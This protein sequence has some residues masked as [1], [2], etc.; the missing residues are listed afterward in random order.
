VDRV[1][2]VGN[3]AGLGAQD[4]LKNAGLRTLANQLAF[5]VSYHEISSSPSFQVEFA[6]SLYFPYQ[7]LAQ[8]P[9]IA[10]EYENIPLR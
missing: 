5:K 7:S 9:N 4:L 10:K 1:F 3:A 2:Q 8:F 6:K